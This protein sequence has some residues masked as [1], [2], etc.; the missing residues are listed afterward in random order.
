VSFEVSGNEVRVEAPCAHCGER[1]LLDLPDSRPAIRM[2]LA[3]LD[4]GSES[5]NFGEAAGEALEHAGGGRLLVRALAKTGASLGD[6][7]RVERIA[8]GIALDDEAEADALEADWREAEEVA[9]ML[10]R[11]PS[12]DPVFRDFRRRLLGRWRP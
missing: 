12:D 9:E 11:P 5:R 7:D 10:R 6:L 1:V 8:L 3:M 4:R 2:G